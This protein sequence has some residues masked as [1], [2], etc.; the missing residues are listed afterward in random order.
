MG[1]LAPLV[2]RFE[3]L[4]SPSSAYSPRICFSPTRIGPSKRRLVSRPAYEVISPAGPKLIQQRVH[5]PTAG[6]KSRI[7]LVLAPESVATP[8]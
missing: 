4:A 8:T 7:G 1:Y 2:D 5:E 6:R 3:V